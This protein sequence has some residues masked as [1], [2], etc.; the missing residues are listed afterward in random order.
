MSTNPLRVKNGPPAKNKRVSLADV[1]RHAGVSANTVSRVVRGDPEVADSTRANITALL[2]EMGY[3]PNYAARALAGKRTG[4]IHVL[5]AAPMFHGHGQ[6][7][8]H[9]LNAASDAGLSVSISSVYM[10]NGHVTSDAIPFRVDGIVILG[11]QD[12]VIEMAMKLARTT[13][14]TLLLSSETNI[15]GVSTVSVDNVLGSRVATDHL[16]RGGVTDI[17]HLMGPAGWNDAHQRRKGFEEACAQSDASLN[18]EIIE[19]GSWN[20]VD[21]FDATYSMGRIPQGIVA[22]NDQIALGA[23]RAV[24]ELGGELPHDTRVVGFDDEAGAQ[25]FSP[26]LTTIRQ[27][28]DRVG[29]TA[30]RQIVDLIAGRPPQ[31]F[32]IPPELVIRT[33]SQIVTHYE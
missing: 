13:P 32:I 23:M 20:A 10:S 5:M 26:P 24:R 21:G 6:T 7:L 9:V 22:S 29:R 25:C 8:L 1:A 11:G 30:I 16:L 4:V 14:T 19:C 28:F 12:P 27:P 2:H 15:D 31:D 18:V 33:S 3:R 17:V